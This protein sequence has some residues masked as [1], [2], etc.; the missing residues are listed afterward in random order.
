[1]TRDT[2]ESEQRTR[3]K[4]GV[5]AGLATAYTLFLVYTAGAKFLL[6]SCVI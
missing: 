5:I 3:V 1:L 4:H 2:Y 6:L